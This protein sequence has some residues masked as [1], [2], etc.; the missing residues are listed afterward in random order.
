MKKFFAMFAIAAIALTFAACGGGDEKKAAQKSE[1]ELQAE[2]YGKL[3]ALYMRYDYKLYDACCE[4]I[5]QW[6]ET[7]GN[8]NA[9]DLMYEAFDAVNSE[10]EAMC[11]QQVPM[12]EAKKKIGL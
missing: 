8:P 12:E 5:D 7:C 11:M 2:R 3:R 10:V 4:E 6:V 9:R 1:F